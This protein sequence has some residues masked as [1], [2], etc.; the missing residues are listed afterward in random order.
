MSPDNSSFMVAENK[1]SKVW[2]LGTLQEHVMYILASSQDLLIC[3]PDFLWDRTIEQSKA[4]VFPT[5]PV[6]G[7]QLVVVW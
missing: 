6:V 4:V 5:S 3:I 2:L 7:A 1:S